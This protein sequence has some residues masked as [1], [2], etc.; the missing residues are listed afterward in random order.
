MRLLGCALV[1]FAA[2]TV[3]A[4]SSTNTGTGPT[5]GTS[6]APSGSSNPVTPPDETPPQNG[7]DGGGLPAASTTEANVAIDGS[8][9]AF[10]ACGGTPQG[11]YDYSAGCIDD[12]FASARA[13]CPTIDTSG[14]K[15]TVK[16]SLHFV[17]N[18]LTRDGVATTSGT[19]VLP[20]TCTQG[21]CAAVESALKSAFDSVSCTG[22]AACTCT[23]KRTDTAHNATTFSVAG[24]TLTTADGDSYAVCAQGSSLAYQGKS[25]F[26]EDG[27][28]ELKKR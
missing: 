8:C 24:N 4:C 17:G 22:I 1:S 26:A 15:V 14:A 28:W 20:A 5:S 23:I 25:A 16:G 19:V 12:V 7:T 18:S 3:A 6:G 27:S 10:A 9:P 11:T 21:Q 13:Q 2:L